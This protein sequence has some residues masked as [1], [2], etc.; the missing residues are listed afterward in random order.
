LIAINH[1]LEAVM[2][3]DRVVVLENGQVADV[4]KPA[5]L[6]LRSEPFASELS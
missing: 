6:A 1:N 4:G 2:G 3:Y 5:E